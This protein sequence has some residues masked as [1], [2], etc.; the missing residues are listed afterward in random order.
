MGVALSQ[1]ELCTVQNC[2]V[3]NH[4][5]NSLKHDNFL[6]QSRLPPKSFIVSGSDELLRVQMMQIILA[7]ECWFKDK[8][9]TSKHYDTSENISPSVL[10]HRSCPGLSRS[11][12]AKG[13]LIHLG[14]I[15]LLSPPKLILS[16]RSCLVN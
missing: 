13:Y 10:S 6:E 12:A 5:D 11:E 8:P 2:S 15:I 16:Q 9:C 14:K 1:D 3:S 7:T 4:Y